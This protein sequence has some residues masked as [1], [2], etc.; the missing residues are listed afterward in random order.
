MTVADLK[1]FLESVPDDAEIK[2]C[3]ENYEPL[4]MNNLNLSFKDGEVVEVMIW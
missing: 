1:R 2:T 3:D 4:D